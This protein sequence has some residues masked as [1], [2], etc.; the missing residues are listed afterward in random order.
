MGKCINHPDRETSSMCMK[1]QI[2]MCEECLSCRDPD[3]YCKY[4][5]SCPIWFMEKRGGS[6]ID[7]VP[8]DNTKIR[9]AA[10]A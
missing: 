3:I 10:S 7:E 8:D 5:S 1:H 6:A 9:Q 4:R 2:F